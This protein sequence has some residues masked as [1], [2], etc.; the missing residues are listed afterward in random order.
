[1][2]IMILEKSPHVPLLV[3]W[4]KDYLHMSQHNQ[5]QFYWL[6]GY[7]WLRTSWALHKCSGY[8]S[9]FLNRTCYANVST[10]FTGNYNGFTDVTQSFPVLWNNVVLNLK[11]VFTLFSPF[12][13]MTDVWYGWIFCTD[14]KK[15]TRSLKATSCFLE[16][17]TV[18]VHGHE[19]A[20]TATE[21]KEKMWRKREDREQSAPLRRKNFIQTIFTKK[22]KLGMP[23]Q[24]SYILFVFCDVAHDT[25]TLILICRNQRGYW[26]NVRAP[27]NTASRSHSDQSNSIMS[28]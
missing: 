25:N 14:A 20:Q 11:R 7:F 1:M 22:W 6:I 27:A 26:K 16:R 8:L 19:R 28:E 18:C 17:Q 21:R 2:L 15:L 3:Y 23:S 5:F 12:Q 24:I 4:N 10:Y 9:P 13:D